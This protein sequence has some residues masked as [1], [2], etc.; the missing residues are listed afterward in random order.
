MES[1]YFIIKNED[2]K[3]LVTS[4]DSNSLEKQCVLG[5]SEDDPCKNCDKC[6]TFVLPTPIVP[7]TQKNV[8][9]TFTD[10]K[11]GLLSPV[12]IACIVIVVLLFLVFIY[13]K[14]FGSHQEELPSNVFNATD[15]LLSAF[16]QL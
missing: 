2:G 5:C 10:P 13:F 7:P 6:N 14:F 8:N 9:S 1:Q 15:D 12:A 11:T 3:Y 16:G 4:S